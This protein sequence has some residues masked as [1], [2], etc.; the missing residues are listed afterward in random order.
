VTEAV[1]GY[2]CQRHKVTV[3]AQVKSKKKVNQ[4]FDFDYDGYFEG[5]ELIE[6]G[7]LIVDEKTF[8]VAKDVTK[9]IES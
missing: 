4:N 5:A 2:N 6:E 8:K 1:N 3:S 7:K 9:V